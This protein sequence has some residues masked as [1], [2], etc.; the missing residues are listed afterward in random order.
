[1]RPGLRKDLEAL[2]KAD[3]RKLASYIDLVLEAHVA[4]KKLEAKKK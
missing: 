2:A 1:M 3:K 4:A